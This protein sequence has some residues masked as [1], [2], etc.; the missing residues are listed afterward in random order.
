MKSFSLPTQYFNKQQLKSLPLPCGFSVLHLS[1][2]LCYYICKFSSFE[3]HNLSFTKHTNQQL[4]WWKYVSFTILVSWL[5]TGDCN[6]TCLFFPSMGWKIA[7]FLY[8]SGAISAELA[9]LPQPYCSTVIFTKSV[10][11]YLNDSLAFGFWRNHPIKL[12]FIL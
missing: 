1:L 8:V 4:P 11:L 5:D 7:S 2:P 10:S 12:P 6:I 3:S 9:A